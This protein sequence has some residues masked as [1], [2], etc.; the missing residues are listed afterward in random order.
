MTKTK[1][2]SKE[3]KFTDFVNYINKAA[4]N[5]EQKTGID[6]DEFVSA[7]GL[8]WTELSNKNNLHMFIHCFKK[9]CLVLIRNEFTKKRG[10]QAKKIF[11]DQEI[12]QNNSGTTNHSIIATVKNAAITTADISLLTSSAK[13]VLAGLMN[14]KQPVEISTKQRKKAQY[15]TNRKIMLTVGKENYKKA[16]QE[17]AELIPG[18]KVAKNLNTCNTMP[19]ILRRA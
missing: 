18:A 6:R 13:K 10:Y 17:I 14:Y 19:I 11:L 3:Y 15:K 9:A 16:L 8:V 5:F 4:F 12:A 1:T 2:T 7:A